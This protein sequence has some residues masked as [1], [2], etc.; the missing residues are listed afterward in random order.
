MM[1]REGRGARLSFVGTCCEPR[2][3][4]IGWCGV[5]VSVG[6]CHSSMGGSL[7][8]VGRGWEEVVIGGHSLLVG[9]GLSSA[10]A[11][12]HSLVGCCCVC[13]GS[14]FIH[15]DRRRS[16]VR[17]QPLS[18]GI[19]VLVWW[20]PLLCAHAGCC[21]THAGHFGGC[22]VIVVVILVVVVVVAMLVTVVVVVVLV[23]LV[24]VLVVVVVVVHLIMGDCCH[25]HGGDVAHCCHVGVV[26]ESE[27]VAW[28][29][30]WGAYMSLSPQWV[31]TTCG[32]S[33]EPR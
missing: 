14:F 30:M 18:L 26:V 5:V 22:L 4:A 1:E 3:L 16:W 29:S 27:C 25:C 6:T 9:G 8:S 32:S 24:V 17:G 10:M 33:D 21:D 15:G 31:L 13:G 7:S 28:Q 23:V 20:S 12:H 19:V 2:V 11:T